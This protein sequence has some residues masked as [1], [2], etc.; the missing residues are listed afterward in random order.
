MEATT[1]DLLDCIHQG[2]DE[3]FSLTLTRQPSDFDPNAAVYPKSG[4]TLMHLIARLGRVQQFL[5]L[6]DKFPNVDINAANVKDGKRPL[7]EAAQFG[8]HEVIRELLN[9][10]QSSSSVDVNSLKR[11]DWSPLMLAATKTG[12]DAYNSVIA[13]LDAGA[14]TSLRNKD[15]WTAFHLASRE[16][17]ENVISA[18]LQRDPSAWNTVSNNQRTPE[19]TAAL[20]GHTAILEILDDAQNRCKGQESMR[21]TDS[22]GTTPFMDAI[23]SGSLE[24]LDHIATSH[25]GDLMV[26][27]KMGRNGLDIGAYVGNATLITHLVSR[28]GFLVDRVSQSSGMTALHWASLEG[29]EDSV[30]CLVDQHGATHDLK[31]SQGRSPLNLAMACNKHQVAKFLLDKFE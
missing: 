9:L 17:D 29:H 31:D 19:H 18:L 10:D 3:R 16:G 20:H 14:D 28:H 12:P 25:P 26:E 2:D 4:D 13:L 1:A 23:K 24:T 21:R 15:G 5:A 22:C 27:D 7:H 11:A 6:L 8:K 30:K